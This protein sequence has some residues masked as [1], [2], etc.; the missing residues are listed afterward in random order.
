M[1]LAQFDKIFLKLL[2]KN[3][4]NRSIVYPLPLFLNRY[5]GGYFVVLNLKMQKFG[6]SFAK[7]ER[8]CAKKV[9]EMQRRELI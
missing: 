9:K 6:Y 7:N 3:P 1:T 5:K 8:I 4:N 2:L